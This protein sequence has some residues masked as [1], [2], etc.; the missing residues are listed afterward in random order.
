MKIKELNFVAFGPF[1]DK[2]L[3]FDEDAGLHIIYGPNE[4]GKSSALRGLKSF[5]YGIDVRTSDNFLHANNELRIQ[6]C[7]QSKG[8]NVLEFVRRKGSKNTLLTP[9]GNPLDEQVLLPFLQGVKL[10]L[11]EALFGID[12]N[13][14]QQGGQEILDQK[15]EVGQTLFSASLGSHSLHA[16]LEGLDTEAESLFKP[17]GSNQKI[18]AALKLYSEL[19]KEIKNNS[20]SS[21]D[22]DEH[23]KGVDQVTSDLTKIQK[24]LK[25]TRSE[26]TRLKR[27]QNALP[28]LAR[29][30]ELLRDLESLGNVVI[31]PDDFVTRH[32][33]AV[34]E[35]DAAQTII[36]QATPRRNDLQSSVEQLCVNHDLL[37]QAETIEDLHARL[38]GHRKA[39]QDQPH[40]KAE[41]QQL[42]TDAEFLLKELRPDLEITQI[43]ILRPLLSRQNAITELGVQKATLIS[44]LEKSESI[45]RDLD[46]QLKDDNKE[47]QNLPTYSS[48]DTLRRAI[49]SA[50]KMGDIDAVIQSSQ[51]DIEILQSQCDEGL[52]RLTLW[53]GQ[54]DSLPGLAVPNKVTIKH[55]AD[56]YD[57]LN[58]RLQKLKDNQESS[59]KERQE[60]LRNLDEMQRVGEVPTEE[61]LMEARSIRDKIWKLLRLEWVDKKDVSAEA[62][63]LI[64]EDSLPDTFEHRLIDSDELS[65]RLRREAKQVHAMATLRANE[66]K[67]TN[68][69]AGLD[70]GLEACAVEKQELDVEWTSIWSDCEIQPRTPLEMSRWLD[71]MDKLVERIEL[72]KNA[73]QK[74]E[75]LKHSRQSHIEL[76]NEQLQEAGEN[77]S[78]SE[79][80]ESVL[81]ECEELLQKLEG[82]KQKRDALDRNILRLESETESLNTDLQLANKKIDDWRKEWLEVMMSFGIPENSTPPEVSDIIDKLRL[83]FEKQKD[84]EKLQIRIGAIDED[85][86]SFKGQVSSMITSISPEHKDLSI[87]DAVIRLNS[88]LRENQSNHTRYE[89]INEQI[90]N[91]NKEIQESDS[92]IKIMTERLNSLAKEA[93]RDNYAELE[94]AERNSEEYLRVKG[95]INSIEQGI[96]QAGEAGSITELQKEAGEIDIDELP[97]QVEELNEKIEDE[98]E[99]RRNELAEAKG[100]K[101]KEIELMDGSDHAA[102]LSDESQSILAGIRSDTERYVRA[103]L[104]SKILRDEIESFRKENQGPLIERASES[105]AVLTGDSFTSLRAD[106]NDKDESVLVGIRAS[107]ERVLIEGMSAGT[108]DQLYLALRLASLE[109][110]MESS[111]PMPFIVDDILVDFDDDRSEAALVALSQ[112]AK[113]T[114]VIMFTHHSR[115]VEQARKIGGSVSIQELM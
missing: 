102:V 50:R 72:L 90:Q 39:S 14:L 63:Y 25:D 32:K 18:N 82:I 70:Q 75:A 57:E 66:N 65:D 93:K 12:H 16:V 101:Q 95:E 3:S 105:F 28:K 80:I 20:L 43:E 76:L 15:G 89:Q 40:L 7:L 52:S 77:H 17:R 113:K 73:R 1:T 69:L 10:E 29:H 107:E 114:Q 35:L 38:G 106:F 100:R 23:R 8:G 78:G 91:A 26:V 27:I 5:L 74:K 103:K 92:M 59:E 104:A 54:L 51:T 19:K 68:Q 42:I 64:T 58:T 110:Y 53:H 83:I 55:F 34:K 112:L 21:R 109:K 81:M 96:I 37:E 49:T 61:D 85:A 4:A 6:G 47:K 30:A 45:Q 88:L 44:K 60:V 24:E 84:A 2:P 97:A 22:W 56:A 13:S 62:S 111:E 11:F 87:E 36:G 79:L 46:K 41:R 9:D 98:L 67:L 108:R 115:V 71:D 31:L 86:K 33:Q 48:S 99:P 94:E